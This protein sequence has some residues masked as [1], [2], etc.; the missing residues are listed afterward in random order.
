[1]AFN[2]VAKKFARPAVAAMAVLTALAVVDGGI[3]M[4]L[5]APA[6]VQGAT[7]GE[8][9]WSATLTVGGDGTARGYARSGFG[10]LSDTDFTL[11]SQNVSVKAIVERP[12]PGKNLQIA[13]DTELDVPQS[14]AMRFNVDGQE[15]RFALAVPSTDAQNNHIYT[16]VNSTD[17]GWTNGQTIALTITALPIVTI[18][19]VTSQVEHKKIAEF[20]VTRTGSADDDLSFRIRFKETGDTAT[21][22]FNAGKSRLTLNHWAAETDESNDPV[23]TITWVVTTGAGYVVGDPAEAEVDVEGPGSTCT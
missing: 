23:C 5:S 13:L 15:H 3:P 18:E 4:S 6:P 1:M 12:S 20:R 8:V 21:A 14:L 19:A 7:E 11:G 22:K 2:D 16:W 17:Y 10:T 9:I